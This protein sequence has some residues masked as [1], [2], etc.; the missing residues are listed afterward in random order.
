MGAARAL[1]QRALAAFR[2][3]GDPWG[4]A[5][6]LTDLASI[7]CAQG[8]HSAAHAAYSE[9]LE[10]F[11]TLR[12]RRGIARALEG[13]ACL[14]SAQ[15]QAKRALTLASAATHLRR[16]ISAPL[17]QAEQFKLDQ[18]L[19]PAR[20]SLS[21]AEGKR[22]WTEGSEMSLENAIQ[23]SLWEPRSAIAG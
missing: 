8:N 3:A 13:F 9:A 15:G 16:S 2:E 21:D 19:I 18:S 7:D 17:P 23:Y 11:A 14:A 22:A 20:E 5:R 10:M 12:H 1:Y 4:S 6:S